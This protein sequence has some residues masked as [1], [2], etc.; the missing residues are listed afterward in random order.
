MEFSRERR[1]LI[2]GL[3]AFTI[4][5]FLTSCELTTRTEPK[6]ATNI[7]EEI[8]RSIVAEDIE[9]AQNKALITG[10]SHENLARSAA[11]SGHIGEAAAHLSLAPISN[12]KKAN[13][14]AAAHMQR[15]IQTNMM[16]ARAKN[17]DQAQAYFSESE[18]NRVRAQAI[19]DLGKR[20]ILETPPKP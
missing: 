14:L 8:K 16:S 20:E 13:I 1:R 11:F 10:I 15:S 18:Y 9:K 4:S 2:L 5:P 6:P 19:L 3:A 17:F 12:H 7:D